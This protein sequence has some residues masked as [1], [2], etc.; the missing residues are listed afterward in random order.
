MMHIIMDESRIWMIGHMEVD[1]FIKT[2]TWRHNIEGAQTELE[3]GQTK[4]SQKYSAQTD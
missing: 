2:L 1:S 4:Q 3:F